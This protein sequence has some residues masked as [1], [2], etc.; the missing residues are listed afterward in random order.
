MGE[1]HDL[2]MLEQAAAVRRREISASDLVAHHLRRIEAYDASVGAFVTVTAEAA[3]TRAAAADAAVAAAAGA[4]DLAGLPPLHGVPVA[5]K[6]LTLTAG[7]RTAF[8][9]AVFADFVPGQDADVVAALQAAG[10]ISLGKTATS[11]FGNALYCETALGSATRNPWDPDRT[12]GGSS[13]GAAAAVAAG[14]VPAAQGSDG[15][16]SLRIPGSICGLVGF[17]PSRGVVSG[18]P[19]GFGAFG[20]PTNGPLARTVTDTAALLDAMAVPA[21]GE[22]YLPPPPPPG[23]YL[24]AAR[25]APPGR[26][27]IGCWTTPMLAEAQ[28]DPACLAVVQTATRLLQD[29]GHEV[30]EV[31]PPVDPQ[32][33]DLFETLWQVLALATPVPPDR[34]AQ[35]QPVTRWLR[36]QARQVTVPR[37]LVVLAQVQAAVRAGARRLAGVDL[38]LSPTLAAPQAPVGWFTAAGDPAGNFARQK[39]FSPYCAVYNITGHP[40]VSLPLGATTDGAP[41]GVMLAANPGA[42]GL[43][44]QV[45]AQVEQAAP[46][47]HRHPALWGAP[48]SANVNAD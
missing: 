40:A 34:E 43:L 25:S 31:A 47:A 32:A 4:G 17:K 33:A 42:D 35:L 15:G 29:A 28:L 16:G 41:V 6:D 48:G 22:P 23:G 45:A 14:M 38:L 20:L 12:A 11:E 18:G 1:L 9:S 10:T 13:G 26:L 21:P 5:I 7:V 3:R 36:E 24:A 44:L 8:G 19:L 46:W 27:R 2:T 39:L 37:L 30:E